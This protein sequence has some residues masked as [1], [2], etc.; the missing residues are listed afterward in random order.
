[1][2]KLSVSGIKLTSAYGPREPIKTKAGWTPSFHWGADYGPPVRH[3][4]G[5]PLYAIMAGPVTRMKDQYGALGVRIGNRAT[6][7]IET[8]HMAG[9]NP[10]LGD[11]AHEGEWLG[12]MGKTGR[13]TGIHTCVF[14][15]VNG[16]RVDPVPFINAQAKKA[17][18]SGDGDTDDEKE[19]GLTMADAASLEAQLKEL[20]GHLNN[21]LTVGGEGKLGVPGIT[22][23]ALKDTQGK[24]D[25]LGRRLAFTGEDG[26]RANYDW[27]PVIYK[28]LVASGPAS[29]NAIAAAVAS[30]LAIPGLTPAVVQQIAEAV[31]AEQAERLTN[32]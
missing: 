5:V 2:A 21:L 16:K 22:Y 11:T 7:A 28:Q 20:R 1:M 4:E 23:T 25:D 14:Y 6:R 8:W 32:G 10:Q 29:A 24:V 3:Q 27:L 31:V 15:W 19:D 30:K 17:V 18:A 9:Y 12:D 26:T 13:A